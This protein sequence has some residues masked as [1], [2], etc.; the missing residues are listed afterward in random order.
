MWVALPTSNLVPRHGLSG[1]GNAIWMIRQQTQI[2]TRP[3][4]TK[5]CRVK[6]RRLTYRSNGLNTGSNPGGGRIGKNVSFIWM[7]D[8]RILTVLKQPSLPD[9]VHNPAKWEHRCL[10]APRTCLYGHLHQRCT[11]VEHLQGWCRGQEPNENKMLTLIKRDR[12]NG[13]QMKCCMLLYS[14]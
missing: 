10:S 13:L 11:S 12:F 9:L 3:R 4:A 6:C 8:I 5:Q 14:K 7:S 2:S 1:R